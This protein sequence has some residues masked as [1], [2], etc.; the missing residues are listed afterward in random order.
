M[1]KAPKQWNSLPKWMQSGLYERQDDLELYFLCHHDKRIQTPHTQ[2][3]TNTHSKQ[4]S[5]AEQ[6]LKSH[7]RIPRASTP[8]RKWHPPDQFS[9]HSIFSCVYSGSAL[10]GMDMRSILLSWT[11]RPYVPV[12]QYRIS[13]VLQCRGTFH[14]IYMEWP[15]PFIAAPSCSHG[16]DTVTAAYHERR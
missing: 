8:A 9:C 5:S 3:H 1:R 16:T 6:H 4:S 14:Y 13:R 10:S 11:S 7:V 12:F 15:W 2:T